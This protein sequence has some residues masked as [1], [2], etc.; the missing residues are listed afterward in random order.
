MKIRLKRLN[1]AGFDHVMILVAFVVV[2]GLIGAFLLYKSFAATTQ[3]NLKLDADQ[4]MCL[5]NSGG[6]SAGN[7]NIILYGCSNTAPNDWVLHSVSG[8]F[9]IQTTAYDGKTVCVDGSAGVGTNASN[10][11][12]VRGNVCSTNSTGIALETWHWSSVTGSPQELQNNSN[13]GCINDPGGSTAN[14]TALI[15]FSCAKTSGNQTLTNSR[16]VE[17]AQAS[18]SGGGGGGV[19]S[20]SGTTASQF[21][22]RA[23][24]WGGTPYAWGGGVHGDG[25]YTDWAK[26]CESGSTH[27]PI[28][29]CAMDCSGFVSVV[30]DDVTGNNFGWTAGDDALSGSAKGDSHWH[31]VSA[32]KAVPGDIITAPGH[33]EF[34]AAVSGGK[35]TQTYGEH[36]SKTDVSAVPYSYISDWG[37]IYHWE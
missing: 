17:V 27:T 14:S 5:N 25:A 32:S 20:C 6:S 22:C 34:V 9:E 37:T 36:D 10:R 19:S 4:G 18:S 13:G 35:V 16:W 3:V 1:Q 30:V 7:H 28:K 23:K 26:N 8:G 11:K 33:V 12:Y 31:V 24:Q 15:M 21:L 29:S 2:F